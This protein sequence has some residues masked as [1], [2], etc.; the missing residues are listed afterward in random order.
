[1]IGVKKI[2]KIPKPI[3]LPYA[4]ARL[5]A[6]IIEKTKLTQGMKESRNNRPFPMAISH[7]Q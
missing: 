1:M 7:K 4:F 6:K 5:I 3:P 2:I